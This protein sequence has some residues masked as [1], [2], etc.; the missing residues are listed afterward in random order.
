ML[1]S[2]KEFDRCPEIKDVNI[3]AV[4]GHEPTLLV[5]T[6]AGMK[7]RVTCTLGGRQYSLTFLKTL[8]RKKA[9]LKTPA[10]MT[11][12][13]YLL[14][15]L[16][17]DAV[18]KVAYTKEK[19]HVYDQPII[20]EISPNETAVNTEINVTITGSGFI[21][22]SSLMCVLVPDKERKVETFKAIFVNSATIICLLRRS[23]RA[24]HSKISVLFAPGSENEKLAR[25]I[26]TKFSFYDPVPVP[27][28][29]EFSTSARFIFV[30]FN[31]SVDCNGK[32]E[33]FIKGS[34]L[35]KLTK[36][37]K[38][39]C[40]NKKLFI[41]LQNSRL[42]PG[43]EMELFLRNFQS[44]RSSYTKHV[45]AEEDHTLT[46]NF[47]GA[48]KPF[49]LEISAPETVGLCDSF[50]VSV[51]GNM[52]AA[53]NWSVVISD[54]PAVTAEHTAD[55]QKLN[56]RFSNLP[57]NQTRV[58]LSARDVIT[59]VDYNVTVCGRADLSG[60]E[61]CVTK[62]V[63]RVG[64]KV[65][66]IRFP[67]TVIKTLPSVTLKLRAIVH[68]ASCAQRNMRYLSFFWSCDGNLEF[69][70]D[71]PRLVVKADQWTAG[72][73]YQ[74][75]LTVYVINDDSLFA[76]AKVTI[77]VKK[78][79][80]KAKIKGGERRTLSAHQEAVCDGS[81]S[82]D[83]NNLPGNP[84]YLWT[85]K[86][87]ERANWYPAFFEN[88]TT[89]N[90]QRL[91]LPRTAVVRIPPNTLPA[92]K[93]C[94]VTLGYFKGDMNDSTSVYFAVKEQEL[95][96]VKMVKVSVKEDKVVF[97]AVIRSTLPE[98]KIEWSCQEEDEDGNLIVI[99]LEGIVLTPAILNVKK[100]PDKDVIKKRVSLVLKKLSAGV[101]LGC[102]C[103]ASHGEAVASVE[104][105]IEVNQPP[106][107]GKCLLE[108][109]EDGKI[110]LTAQGFEDPNSEDSDELKYRCGYIAEGEKV[111][112]RAITT[113][114]EERT[115]ENL[116][117]P[118][119]D[120]G[121][122]YQ[123][124][125]FVQAKDPSGAKTHSDCRSVRVPPRNLNSEEIANVTDDIKQLLG[126]NDFFESVAKLDSVL[127][128][129]NENNE[130]VE[131][132]TI[133][134]KE[135]I[136]EILEQCTTFLEDEGKP[137]DAEDDAM[138]MKGI[139][140]ALD[141]VKKRNKSVEN[142]K[143]M[144]E[145]VRK[146]NSP[147]PKESDDSARRKRR[148]A[149]DGNGEGE[150]AE[151]ETK[152]P[153]EVENVLKIYSTLIEPKNF[154]N[155][156]M[157]VKSDLVS[158]VDELGRSMCQGIN[159]GEQAVTAESDF[160]VLRSEK[161]SFDTV[162]VN[163]THV[164]CE[165]CSSVVQASAQVLL[166]QSLKDLYQSW[167]CNE[168]GCNGACVVSAQYPHDLLATSDNESL[169][170]D[171]VYVKLFNPENAAHLSVSGLAEPVTFSIPLRDYNEANDTAPVCHAWDELTLS[172]ITDD[173][174]TGLISENEN[175]DVVIEC[176]FPKLGFISV[177]A[178][179]SS[180]LPPPTSQPP[181][182]TTQNV[183]S[184]EPVYI[185]FK[186][187]ANFADIIPN[188]SKKE[189]FT[190]AFRQRTAAV[191]AINISRIAN[192][193][194]RQGS[195]LV[196]F[197]LLPGGPG[198]NNASAATSMLMKLVRDGNF[199]VTLGDGQTLVA[200][201][202]SF[203]TSATQWTF[204]TSASQLPTTTTHHEEEQ[205]ETSS[206]LSTGAL[207]GVIVGSVLAVLLLV[208][209]VIVFF[210]VRGKTSKVENTTPTQSQTRL[211]LSSPVTSGHDNNEVQQEMST[212]DDKRN[213]YP[214]ANLREEADVPLPG[215]P[216]YPPK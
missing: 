211:T 138:M 54:S 170:S 114:S 13:E 100:Q 177:F 172:W 203:L 196:S 153:D 10:G 23:S 99:D 145:K 38:C 173:I 125:T 187:V 97:E 215:T 82:K 60:Q 76:R 53:M 130:S 46:C 136:N 169:I 137:R 18:N 75:I 4:P 88:K 113:W 67:R 11:A 44:Q 146:M 127:K 181:T 96:F 143:E 93:M 163:Y 116:D 41:Q 98:I 86:C 174:S 30:I 168:D 74:C 212:G 104:E 64:K 179:N 94:A 189:A 24:K 183:I 65:P 150:G 48:S 59:G 95:P 80:M 151:V 210:K 206:D 79:K 119:G 9:A 194:V 73:R 166:G 213:E 12:G 49:E 40:Q 201:S 134:L 112:Y 77:V 185:Q 140:V 124:K 33:R 58:K 178:V 167:D 123:L 7:E 39:R 102:T 154:D 1:E 192:V 37:S 17:D 43:D 162:D 195:I 87:Q 157:A 111:K 45:S 21:N 83:P 42:R 205:T 171:V 85:V 78:E 2:D 22:S 16:F 35:N 63:R 90:L 208:V 198:E 20:N 164:T 200:D 184:E 29:C 120:P 142:T 31:K 139:H 47:N 8:S 161:N 91:I 190:L 66:K 34:A 72:Q 147:R 52:R 61:A 128:G 101:K 122:D 26:A 209:C 81:D 51:K 159:T 129:S 133:M 71:S 3:R 202:G 56:L 193:E 180:V 216:Q 141:G 132:F 32:C 25:A 36:D 204:S 84:I 106:M 27:L 89:G 160:V 155:A 107:A 92:N 117:L 19:I 197:T 118:P 131:A 110:S 14:E 176:R 108:M 28:R 15:C 109:S 103:Q 148:A 214:M 6:V 207:V 175:G 121:K 115:C 68:A 182:V 69:D 156:S 158:L 144:S 186:L 126:Q 191:M 5:L 70:D 62:T 50:V 199:S 188:E 57:S 135:F 165:N 105:K 55:V 152:T 149:D